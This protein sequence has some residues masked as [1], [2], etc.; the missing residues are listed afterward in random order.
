MCVC[1][2]LFLC[3]FAAASSPPGP[4]ALDRSSR[5]CCGALAG[6][7]HEPYLFLSTRPLFCSHAAWC[8][9][10][11]CEL[12]CLSVCLHQEAGEHLNVTQGAVALAANPPKV[13]TVRV[14]RYVRTNSHPH[15]C[16]PRLYS[17]GTGTKH[18]AAKP[19]GKQQQLTT[20]TKTEKEALRTPPISLAHASYSAAP[21]K[22][23]G[24]PQ[25]LCVVACCRS[26]GH[27][28]TSAA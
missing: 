4:C 15:T 13:A 24:A 28:Y 9:L 10:C 11:V 18:R 7:L 5:C 16:P 2:C 25:W 3:I 23:N 22:Q 1:L 17:E 20:A 21:I 26:V 6:F 14:D 27:F 12:L 19:K 8:Y